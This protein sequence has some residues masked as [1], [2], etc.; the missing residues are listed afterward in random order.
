MSN[1]HKPEGVRERRTYLTRGAA[2][3]DVFK[4]IEIFYNTT[5]EHANNGM[6]SLIDYGTEENER[7]QV[8]R[9][10]GAPQFTNSATDSAVTE[11]QY[12]RTNIFKAYYIG[13][14]RSGSLVCNNACALLFAHDSVTVFPSVVVCF[15]RYE[16]IETLAGLRYNVAKSRTV[17]KTIVD[18]LKDTANLIDSC[19]RKLRDGKLIAAPDI[20]VMHGAEC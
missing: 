19:A 8:S 6:L 17:S 4:Y 1:A 9:K 11:V 12:S 18:V 20:R 3:P 7:Q 2:R 14:E 16:G 15:L 13:R 10:L 5:R